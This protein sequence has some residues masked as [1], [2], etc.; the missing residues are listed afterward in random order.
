MNLLI[1]SLLLI[2]SAIML[3]SIHDSMIAKEN[4]KKEIADQSLRTERQCFRIK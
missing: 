2:I 4:R 3:V 1:G